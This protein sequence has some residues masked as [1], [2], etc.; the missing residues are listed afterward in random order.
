[1]ARATEHGELWEAIADKRRPVV[2]VSRDDVAGRRDTTTV[3]A[4]TR[5][6]RGLPTEVI[7]DHRDGFAQISTVNC[8]DLKTIRKATLERRLGRLSETKIAL[9]DD[10]L[11]FALQL[12]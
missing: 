5:T 9:L 3:A 4:I 12:R 11:R 8:D 7:L 10:A 2:V 6:V 1:M